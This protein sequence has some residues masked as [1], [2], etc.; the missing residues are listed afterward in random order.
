[1]NET[2]NKYM[3]PR[4]FSGFT[5]VLLVIAAGAAYVYT[6][7]TVIGLPLSYAEEQTDTSSPFPSEGTSSD[8]NSIVQSQPAGVQAGGKKSPTA[9]SLVGIIACLPHKGDGP[10]TM[11]CAIGLKTDDGKYFALTNFNYPG[12]ADVGERVRIAG[13]TVTT[14]EFH[15]SYDIVGTFQVASVEKI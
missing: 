8:Q 11:E 14:D 1:M 2:S 7:P 13:V 3:N 6:H 4:M 5:V 15:A 10:H 9:E 12:S